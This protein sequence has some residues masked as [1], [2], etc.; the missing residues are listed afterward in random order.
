MHIHLTAKLTDNQTEQVH[1][2]SAKYAIPVVEG[3]ATDGLALVYDEQGLGLVDAAEKQQTPVRA[4]LNSAEMQYRLRKSTAKSEAIVKAI[5][6]KGA[7]WHIVDA[8]PGLG[9]DAMVMAHFGCEVTMIERSPVVAALLDD[10]LYWLGQAQPK[11]ASRIMLLHDNSVAAMV[12]WL[13]EKAEELYPEAIYLDPMFPHRKKS[14]LV[15]KQ[16]QLFQQLLG[17]D[18]DANA[19]LEPAR[20]LAKRRVVVKRPNSAPALANTAPTL[21]ISSKKHRFDVYLAKQA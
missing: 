1:R 5:G 3:A 17:P 11:L 8:T 4:E 7:P 21:A 14:A 2:L 13:D 20:K 9:R 6:N 19:L 18:S 10:A 12:K 16:M 15:K